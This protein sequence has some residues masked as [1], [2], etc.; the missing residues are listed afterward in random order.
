MPETAALVTA[1]IMER[2]LCMSCLCMKTGADPNAIEVTFT[3]IGHVLAL[4]REGAGR[5]RACGEIGV[6]FS[7]ERPE[8]QS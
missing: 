6:V 8:Q 7:L 4:K 5:C 3:R 1:L 2:P